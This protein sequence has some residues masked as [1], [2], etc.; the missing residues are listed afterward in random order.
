MY[1]YVPQLKPQLA[2]P[3]APPP[4]YSKIEY[5]DDN[6]CIICYEAM[7]N[8]NSVRLECGHRFHKDVC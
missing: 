7:K 8:F 2:P 6:N 1:M 5:N 4:V 3:K